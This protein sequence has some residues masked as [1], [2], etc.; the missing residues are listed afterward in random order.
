M[1]YYFLSITGVLFLLIIFTRSFPFL[2]SSMLAKS[3][4]MQR[5]GK[6]LSAYIML[7]LVIYEV[8]PNSFKTYPY[9]LPALFSLFVVLLA[10]LIF[11]K[12]LLSMVLGTVSFVWINL[13][14]T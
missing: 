14:Y 7:L 13:N 4:K 3:E 10:H 1:N 2:F 12:P 11:R 9:G 6:R 5:V 8:N